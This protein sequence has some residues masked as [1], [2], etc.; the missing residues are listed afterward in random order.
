[1]EPERERSD[2][3]G[4]GPA[5]EGVRSLL[6]GLGIEIGL[7][8]DLRNGLLQQR[9]ALARDDAAELERVVHD[10]GRTLLA[11]R[12]TRRER[13]RLVEIVTGDA[14]ST[15]PD[16]VQRLTIA[17]AEPCRA[18]VG[19]LHLAARAAQRE[20]EV[21]QRVIRKAIETGEQFLHQ[22][23]T[24][25]AGPEPPVGYPAAAAQASSGLLLNQRA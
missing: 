12:E 5:A 16:L 11:L 20:L 18:A 14:D 25:S 22:M 13:A 24:A 1:M 8:R 17:E 19:E 9:E 15:L 23:L 10:I 4:A 3:D 21:N 6:A 2:P 7:L